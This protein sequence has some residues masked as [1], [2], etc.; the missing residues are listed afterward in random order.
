M[1]TILILLM[2]RSGKQPKAQAVESSN[3]MMF[4]LSFKKINLSNNFIICIFTKH[5]S[6]KME[7]EMGGA[8]STNDMKNA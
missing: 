2:V 6:H 5:Y 1:D 3:N 8:R 7:R 4:I